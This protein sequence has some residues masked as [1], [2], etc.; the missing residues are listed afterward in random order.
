MFSWFTTGVGNQLETT[1]LQ[2]PLLQPPFE[3]PKML[4]GEA[5]VVLEG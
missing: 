5:A 1:E 3:D 2:A 4:G